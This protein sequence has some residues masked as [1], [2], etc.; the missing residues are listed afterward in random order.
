MAYVLADAR[1]Y[2][3]TAAAKE[4][5]NGGSALVLPELTDEIAQLIEDLGLWGAYNYLCSYGRV[6]Y[7]AETA[8]L[9]GF[10]AGD[11]EGWYWMVDGAGQY[12]TPD[13]ALDVANGKLQEH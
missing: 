9:S 2:D 5:A 6:A 4:L 8:T 10:G 1:Q 13:E 7:F 11:P 3:R 12:Q